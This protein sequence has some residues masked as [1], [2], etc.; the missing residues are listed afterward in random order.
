GLVEEG[1]EGLAEDDLAR[2]G[3]GGADVEGHGRA[4]VRGGRPAPAQRGLG[5]DNRN[6]ASAVLRR[7]SPWDAESPLRFMPAPRDAPALAPTTPVR[8]RGSRRG[9]GGWRPRRTPRRRS[10]RP[11]ARPAAAR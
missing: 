7:T 8:R 6:R 9:R 5:E 1:G 4:G 3:R 2:A 10:A 11:R